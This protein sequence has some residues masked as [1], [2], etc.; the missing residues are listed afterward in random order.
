MHNTYGVTSISLMC[1]NLFVFFCLPKLIFTFCILYIG[2]RHFLKSLIN[3]DRTLTIPHNEHHSFTDIG[4]F[5]L[6]TAS[7]L[8]LMGEKQFFPFQHESESHINQVTSDKMTLI[9]LYFQSEFNKS[10]QKIG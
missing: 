10:F 9:K 2:N 5:M 6:M 4:G 1:L 3:D 8:S 7:H